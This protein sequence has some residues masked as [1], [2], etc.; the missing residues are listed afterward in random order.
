MKLSSWKA[1][2]LSFAGHVTLAKSVMEA[3]PIYRMITNMLPRACINEINKLQR[4]FIWG[5]TDTK[6]N[7]HAVGWE[8]VI[9]GKSDGGLG[10]RDLNAMH[11]ACVMKLGCKIIN[12]E[13]ELWCDILRT[14][15]KAGESNSML[16][17]KGTDSN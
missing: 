5:D 13:N 12:N 3:I 1:R 2:H 15:Y 4:K 8:T 6:K 14:K 16:R 7:F 17:A 9:K 10:L 11:E